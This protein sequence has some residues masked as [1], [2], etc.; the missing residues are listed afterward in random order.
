M[1]CNE[2][3]CNLQF[4]S[5]FAEVQTS[6]HLWQA[7]QQIFA[8]I[9]TP[10]YNSAKW[11]DAMPVMTFFC[12][13]FLQVAGLDQSVLF[14]PDSSQDEPSHPL[15]SFAVLWKLSS[16]VFLLLAPTGSLVVKVCHNISGGNFF[17][18]SLLKPNDSF[19]EYF[20]VFGCDGTRR[21]TRTILFVMWF[22]A[23]KVHSA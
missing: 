19:Y 3:H 11:F 17:E 21:S 22:L 13:P 15:L 14:I 7:L 23:Q 6:R 16:F 8:R 12:G 1:F 9:F 10:F 18:L 5:R 20:N 4:A 2:L